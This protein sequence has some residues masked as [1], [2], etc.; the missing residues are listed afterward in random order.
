VADKPSL[1]HPPPRPVGLFGRALEVDLLLWS[2]WMTLGTGIAA[3]VLT[4]RKFLI[5]KNTFSILSGLKTL[6]NEGEILLFLIIGVFS[7]LFPAAKILLMSGIW[8]L[9]PFSRPT[10]DKL[11]NNLGWISRWSMLD[12]YVVAL[13]VVIVRLGALGRVQVRWGI[14][15]FALS[16]ILST[17]A[18]GRLRRGLS[19]RHGNFLAPAE[20]P[21]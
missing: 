2:S 21:R 12:V 11:L 8:Y 13:L 6:W 18:S 4:F 19:I 9:R 1:P 10:S 3:P 17:A 16:V 14:Y 15:A 7:V 20:G 5:L